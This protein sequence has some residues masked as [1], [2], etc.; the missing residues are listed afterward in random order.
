MNCRIQKNLD[1]LTPYSRKV[2]IKSLVDVNQKIMEE[3]FD[4]MKITVTNNLFKIFVVACNEELSIGKSRML[5]IL[6]NV[7]EKV[8]NMHDDNDDFFMLLEKRCKQI[9]GEDLYKRFFKDIP[10]NALPKNYN[11]I[12]N[13]LDK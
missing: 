7:G 10:F 3:K 4:E 5:K 1:Q 9:L 8:L 12:Q 6:Q 13:E 2:L 11:F